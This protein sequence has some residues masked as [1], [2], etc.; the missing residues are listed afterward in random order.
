[1]DIT[2]GSEDVK[3]MSTEFWWGNVLKTMSWMKVKKI[4]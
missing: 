3:V 1:M 4:G 2:R